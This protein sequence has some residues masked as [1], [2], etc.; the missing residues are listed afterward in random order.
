MT[1]KPQYNI[2]V[3]LT[4]KDGNVFNLIGIVLNTL[5]RNSVPANER[6]GVQ[7]DLLSSNSYDE[8]LHKISNYVDVL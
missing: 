5:K 8:V 6:E 1:N 3:Q 4:G 7:V 2:Q